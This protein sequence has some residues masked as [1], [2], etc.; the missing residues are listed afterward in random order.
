MLRLICDKPQSLKE[1]T[2]NNYAQASF[3]WSYLLRNKEIRVNGKKTATDLFLL[4]GDT[5]EYYLT[6]K[7][8]DKT[9]FYPV[10]EDENFLIV[11]KESGVNSEAVFAA[12]SREGE[13]YFIHRLDRNTKGL[14]AFAKTQA[15]ETA[16]LNA[17]KTR[18]VEKIYLALLVG[19]LPQKK[20]VLTAYLKKDEGRATVRVA[21][22]PNSG[23]DKIV[24]EYE[25]LSFDREKG[26]TKAA[27]TLHTGKTHQIRAHFAHIGNPV[28]GDMKYGDE[29]ANKRFSL[30][31]QQLVAKKLRFSLTGEFAYLNEK[32]FYSRFGVDLTMEE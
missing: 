13:A 8:A 25:T 28:L 26:L 18:A 5:V 29:R 3:F 2:E 6:P 23:Y 20:G 10:Y 9:A 24:T 1:F 14:L 30:A 12:L 27:I 17:F 11:D 21:S 15:G 22:F 31:R 16:L 32:I 7:Q 19:E 4:A